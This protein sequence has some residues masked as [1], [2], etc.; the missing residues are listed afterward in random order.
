MALEASPQQN[1]RRLIEQAK[2]K[3]HLLRTGTEM[4]EDTN[5]GKN[6]DRVIEMSH[7][8]DTA[9]NSTLI[10]RYSKM[11]YICKEDKE[12]KNFTFTLPGKDGKTG[13]EIAKEREERGHAVHRTMMKPAPKQH[14]AGG[15]EESHEVINIT[16]IEQLFSVGGMTVGR[17]E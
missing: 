9:D 2:I 17:D 3:N 1:A 13:M 6:G 5:L 16:E 11:G 14:H 7:Q 15:I 8:R 12:A 10:R 4:P